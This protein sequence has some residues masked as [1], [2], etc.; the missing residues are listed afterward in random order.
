MVQTTAPRHAYSVKEVATLVGLE[1]KSIRRAIVRGD[2][3]AVRAEEGN[4]R[5]KFLITEVAL[6]EWLGER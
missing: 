1:H 4:P 2:L 3:K 5:S 6:Y